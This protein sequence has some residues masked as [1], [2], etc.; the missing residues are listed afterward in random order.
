MSLILLNFHPV[1]PGRGHVFLRSGIDRQGPAEVTVDARGR[2]VRDPGGCARI[3]NR[4]SQVSLDEEYVAVVVQAVDPCWGGA[5]QE[6]LGGISIGK[7]WLECQIEKSLEFWVEIPYT[8]KKFK[9]G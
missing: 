1:V 5:D 4:F 6:V 8:N 7:F 9:N 3:P 2:S